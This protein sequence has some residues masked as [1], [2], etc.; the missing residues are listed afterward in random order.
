MHGFAYILSARRH[1][2]RYSAFKQ[3]HPHRYVVR[4][5]LVHKSGLLIQGNNLCSW[6]HKPSIEIQLLGGDIHIDTLSETL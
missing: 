1:T 4:T 6:A 5:I 3:Y 2:Y